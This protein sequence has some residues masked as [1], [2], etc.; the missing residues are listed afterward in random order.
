MENARM[1]KETLLDPRVYHTVKEVKNGAG[2][3]PI[4][5]P[6]GWLHIAHAVRS[7][8]A[9]LRYVLYAFLCDKDDPTKITHSP[10][11]YFLAP[12]GD[13]R[14]GDVSNVAFSNGV[15]SEPGGRVLIYYGSSDTRLH[16][17]ESTVDRL[18][19][20][21]RNT[22]ADPLTSSASVALRLELIRK[23]RKH[24]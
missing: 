13:E 12:E 2:A 24:I 6:A 3:P 18:V 5:T 15:I 21:V 23:N 11:G 19:D 20:Y 9:G 4:E 22:P 16:V 8:A 7:T 1:E 10:G 17:A 14:V